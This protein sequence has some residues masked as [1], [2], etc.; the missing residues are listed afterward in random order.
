MASGEDAG[1]SGFPSALRGLCRHGQTEVKA[2]VRELRAGDPDVISRAFGTIGWNK[3]REQYEKYLDEQNLGLRKVWAAFEGEAFCG[4][5]TLV[6]KPE[7]KYSP[8]G[9]IPEIQD[10]N[11]LPA[12]RKRGL[13]TQLMDLA[14][15]EAAKLSGYVG[16]GVGLHSGY[17]S[18]QRMY[19]A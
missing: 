13:G 18:A 6:P 9:T 2:L 14:E 3:P 1:I 5:V 7:H 8:E 12:F 4:Y 16:L 11:V 19:V 10:F 17:G 15:S